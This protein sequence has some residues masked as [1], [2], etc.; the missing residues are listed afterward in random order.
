VQPLPLSVKQQ[1]W[2][3]NSSLFFAAVVEAGQSYMPVADFFKVD[4]QVCW[5]K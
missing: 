5:S 3:L 2:E 4:R 1:V